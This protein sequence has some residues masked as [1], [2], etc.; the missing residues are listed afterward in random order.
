MNVVRAKKR[1]GQHFLEDESTCQHIVQS[2]QAEN[3]N[4]LEIGAGMGALT[5]LLL[6]KDNLKLMV[7]EIDRQS[8]D[9]LYKHFP[10]LRHKVLADDF[11]KVNLYDIFADSFAVI[12]NFP[13]NISSQILFKI[14]DC[15]DLIYEV[16]G[17]FQKE[18][19]LR[20]TSQRGNKNYGIL[21]VLLQAFYDVEYL[22]EVE[23]Q[24]FHPPPKVTS[25]VIR[26]KRNKVQTLHCDE[27][28]FKTIVK[29]AFNQRRKMLRNSLQSIP[30][31]D[32]FHK[33]TLFNQRPEQLSVDDFVTITNHAVFPL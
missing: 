33:C 1:L 9:F 6:Q 19:A 3:G 15:K 12:G 28:K 27:D 2:L 26:L 24:M 16:V 5:R 11:L 4:V 22:F 17:M 7:I 10:A 23:P 25:A 14:L 32:N 21:S 8:V 18:V 13:Y 30:F 31:K 29:T 20:I